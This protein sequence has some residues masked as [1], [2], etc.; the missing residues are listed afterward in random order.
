MSQNELEREVASLTGETVAIIRRRG[1][2]LLELECPPPLVVDWDE[3]DR[4]RVA[5]GPER[6]SN[7]QRA[8]R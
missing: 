1:F 3:L 5:P 6:S 4:L 2:S 7:G 8:W